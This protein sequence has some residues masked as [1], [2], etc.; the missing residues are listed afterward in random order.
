VR[1]LPTIVLGARLSDG[2][3]VTDARTFVDG[4]PTTA[5]AGGP[6]P[7]DPGPHTIRFTGSLGDASVDVTYNLTIAPGGH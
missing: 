2:S 7:V 4:A 3:D 1:D 6:V 5:D